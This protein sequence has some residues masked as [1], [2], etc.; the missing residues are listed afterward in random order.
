VRDL[1]EQVLKES[2]WAVFGDA[3]PIKAEAKILQNWGQK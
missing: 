1:T 2:F 3:A